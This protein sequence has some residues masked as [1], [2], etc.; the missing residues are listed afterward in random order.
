M[1]RELR[2]DEE[3]RDELC[4]NLGHLFMAIVRVGLERREVMI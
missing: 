2:A 1:W 4:A 3:V